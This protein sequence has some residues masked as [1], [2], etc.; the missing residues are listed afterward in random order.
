MENLAG[1]S[2]SPSPFLRLEGG[3]QGRLRAGAGGGVKE[4]SPGQGQ[5]PH[6]AEGLLFLIC[7]AHVIKY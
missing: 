2:H 3:W 6:V 4:L 7:R 5:S 1:S